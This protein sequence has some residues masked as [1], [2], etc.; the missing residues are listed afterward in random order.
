MINNADYRFGSAAFAT[1]NDARRAGMLKQT[2]TSLFVGFK[3]GDPSLV[4]ERWW[5][6][7]CRWR[8]RR[9]APRLAIVQYLSFDLFGDDGHSGYEGRISCHLS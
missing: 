9:Q 1:K 6:S 4:L 8:T 5:R 2:D 3:E 7:A